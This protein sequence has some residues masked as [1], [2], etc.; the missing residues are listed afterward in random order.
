MSWF[1]VC[2]VTCSLLVW[3]AGPFCTKRELRVCVIYNFCSNN[4]A[5]T[6]LFCI[7]KHNRYH[8]NRN[9]SIMCWDSSC[10][11]RGLFPLVAHDWDTNMGS[12]FATATLVVTLELEAEWCGPC[13]QPTA[14]FPSSSRWT[15]PLCFAYGCWRGIVFTTGSSTILSAVGGDHLFAI[16]RFPWA[17]CFES[18]H[19]EG[20][21]KEATRTESRG[22]E[23]PR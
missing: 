21:S 18:R 14:P 12:A 5:V 20:Y 8:P 6:P 3:S 7:I 15:P 22:D 16:I 4:T 13:C 9:K 11:Q 23:S 2:T 1:S 19:C 10:K 17:T